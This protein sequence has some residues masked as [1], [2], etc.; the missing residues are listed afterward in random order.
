MCIVEIFKTYPMYSI[1]MCIVE[2]FNYAGSEG[3]T[4]ELLSTVHVI[5]RGCSQST[6]LIPIVITLD[7]WPPPSSVTCTP[8]IANDCI[9]WC[10][11]C[12]TDDFKGE[13]RE[14]NNIT[15]NTT[16]L[17][18]LVYSKSSTCMFFKVSRSMHYT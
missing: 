2:N 15:H 6:L 8:Y 1:I 12:Q 13:H 11:V 7:P 9:V 16:I 18:I 4:S 5:N 10:D 14:R 17:V 3:S